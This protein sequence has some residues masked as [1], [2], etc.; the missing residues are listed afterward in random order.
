MVSAHSGAEA[1]ERLHE[2]DYV[3]IL[4]DVHMPGLDGYQTV[5]LIRQRDPFRDIPIVFLTAAHNPPKDIH[6]GYALGAVDY[7]AKPIDPEVLRAKVRALA[8]L[9]LRGA[10]AERER[11]KEAERLKD[12]SSPRS[13]TIF[14][15]HSEPSCWGPRSSSATPGPVPRSSITPAR[16]SAQR[17]AWRASSRTFSISRAASSWEESSCHRAWRTSGISAAPLSKSAASATRGAQF[18]SSFR[19][20]WLDCG[21]PIGSGASSP[22]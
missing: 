18:T 2:Q 12:C 14:A 17:S 4:M 15:A 13:G 19:A 3:L 5:R 6:R 20:I 11:R 9:Y 10:R 8:S 1:L 7:V 21:I 16:S 22:T